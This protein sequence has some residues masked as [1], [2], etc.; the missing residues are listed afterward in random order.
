MLRAL[1]G[2][3]PGWGWAVLGALVLAS[4]GGWH[5][6]AVHQARVQGRADVR[7]QWA[8][9]E[10]ARERQAN[11]DAMRRAEA[12]MVAA[13]AHETTRAG[14]A[15]NLNEARHALQLALNT[16][17]SCP[18][19]APA[20]PEARLGDVLLPAAVMDSLRRAAE[21]GGGERADRAA[22]AEPGR[23]MP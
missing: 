15:H 4:V 19:G 8:A 6:H 14:L 17:L 22:A 1:L 13:A 2:L 7:T 16:A 18:G 5:L 9:A 23:A 10:Q 12:A 20:A 21:G 11:A 3:V